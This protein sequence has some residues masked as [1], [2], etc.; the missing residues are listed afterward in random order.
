[1]VE[2]DGITVGVPRLMPGAAEWATVSAAEASAD[3][4]RE[5]ALRQLD[6]RGQIPC[7]DISAAVNFRLNA[8]TAVASAGVGLEAYAS[9]HLDRLSAETAAAAAKRPLNERYAEELPALFGV[10]PPTKEDWW[11]AFRRVQ[12]LAALQRHGVERPVKKSGLVGEKTLNQRF[13]DR[14]YVGAAKT[15]LAA[16]EYFTPD[17]I[18]D[19]RQSALR[20]LTD[21][22]T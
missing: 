6:R 14:E 12:S 20:A 8:G 18:S 3:A 21:Q 17:W 2:I 7:V 11:P 16:F 13:Y 5:A 4:Y 10:D 9:F 19:D 22:R 15:M 1:M